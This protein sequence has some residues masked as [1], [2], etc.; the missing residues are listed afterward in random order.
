MQIIKLFALDEFKIGETQYGALLVVPALVVAGASVPLGT[1]G[2]R[3]GKARAVRLGMGICAFSM[4]AL[5]LIK[6][7]IALIIG[8]SLIG[9]GFVIAFP[10]WM[11][12]ISAS[13]TPGQR[14][15]VMGAVG[16]VQGLGAMIGAPT[17]GYLYEHAHI[18]ISL[19]PWINAHY[20]P[21]IGCALL[22]LIA[23]TL[24]MT[25]I[26]EKTVRC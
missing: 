25:T 2:D 12:L 14:G 13:C 15:A 10:A 1:I 6:S 22:L 9:I 8:G 16:T 23:W 19:L 3:I 5:I 17:G 11:A 24:C 7:Q 4:W 20:A 21:F 18:R 26:K